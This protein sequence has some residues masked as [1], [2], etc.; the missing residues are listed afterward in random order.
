MRT[1][2]PKVATT[3]VA[4][5][6]STKFDFEPAVAALSD[7][8]KPLQTLED[9]NDGWDDVRGAIRDR[10]KPWQELKE[11]LNDMPAVRWAKVLSAEAQELAS[12]K[13]K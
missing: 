6:S 10:Q 5:S 8:F 7:A 1:A 13:D 3:A 11:S 2:A 9:R 4:A 12:K